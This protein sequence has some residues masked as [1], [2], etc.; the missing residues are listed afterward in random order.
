[1]AIPLTVTFPRD[2]VTAVITESDFLLKTDKWAQI[3]IAKRRATSIQDGRPSFLSHDQ[4]QID[5]V[6]EEINPEPAVE[7]VRAAAH[8]ARVGLPNRTAK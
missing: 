1:M 3:E 8:C 4:R 5:L 6:P 2:L 7:R